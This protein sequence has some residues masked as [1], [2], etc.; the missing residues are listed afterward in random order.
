MS[1]PP[2]SQVKEIQSWFYDYLKTEIDPYDFGR[3]IPEWAEDTGVRLKD[4]DELTPSDLKPVKLKKFHD[5]LVANEKGIEWVGT[6]DVYAPAYLYFNEVSKM[7]TGSWGIHFTEADPFGVFDRGTTLD[8]LALSSYKN[9]KDKVDCSK[10]LTDRIGTAEVVFGFSFTADQR[11]VLSV[12]RKYGQNAVLFQT[13]GAVRAWHIG[14]EEYQMIF[15]L[16]SEYNVIPMFDPR[17]GDIRIETEDGGEMTFKS[18]DEVIAYVEGL[19]QGVRSNPG[20]RLVRV[21]ED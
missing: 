20:E 5:W 8:G 16:C 14:D 19:E 12:G 7:E 1:K 18:L 4:V 6:G 3:F 9:T 13:D 21:F 11:N 2:I 17:P 10:N 15:P